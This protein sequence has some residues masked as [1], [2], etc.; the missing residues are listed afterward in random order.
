ML[1]SNKIP[2]LSSINLS[3]NSI[4]K[5]FSQFCESLL[6][7]QVKLESVSFCNCG[8]NDDSLAELSNIINAGKLFTLK[9]IELADNKFGYESIHHFSQMLSSKKS[10]LIETVNLSSIYIYIIYFNRLWFNK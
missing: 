8:L 6:H 10:P 9:S 1:H 3:N 5:S 7:S 4:R 2:A